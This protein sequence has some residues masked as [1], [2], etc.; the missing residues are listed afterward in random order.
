MMTLEKD[1]ETNDVY[2]CY[3]GYGYGSNQMP[4][5]I[6]LKNI[7]RILRYGHSYSDMIILHRENQKKLI[8]DLKEIVKCSPQK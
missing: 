6:R 7:W 4:W 2:F 8:K 5:S 3:W 1:D